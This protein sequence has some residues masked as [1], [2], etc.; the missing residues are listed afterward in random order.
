MFNHKYLSDWQKVLNNL[1]VSSRHDKE[2]LTI[3]GWEDFNK[4]KKLGLKLFHSKKKKK[5]HNILNSYKRKQ[6]SRNG[7]LNFYLSKL[8]EIGKPITAK[9]FAKMTNKS[10]RVIN[11][12]LKKLAEKNLI[13]IDKSEIAWKYFVLD[14]N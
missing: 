2:G 1:G 13:K 9:E 10:K 5:W 6:V 7:A 8:K 3:E 4:L 14:Q 11:H 12:F